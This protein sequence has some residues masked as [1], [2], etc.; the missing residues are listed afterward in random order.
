MGMVAGC[1]GQSS[2]VADYLGS[3]RDAKTGCS[4]HRGSWMPPSNPILLG[5]H[6]ALPRRHLFQ[7]TSLMFLV[8]KCSTCSL[9]HAEWF[10]RWEIE[11]TVSYHS[12]HISPLSFL[13]LLFRIQVFP[14]W[15]GHEWKIEKMQ[16]LVLWKK[17]R[18]MNFSCLWRSLGEPCKRVHW[19]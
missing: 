2:D 18:N 8:Q 3:W 6:G 4:S 11:D 12:F 16:I 19:S 13:V 7:G 9:C 14:F 5:A 15:H 10:N 17:D 1:M